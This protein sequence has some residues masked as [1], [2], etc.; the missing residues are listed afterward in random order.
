MPIAIG[1]SIFKKR[2]WLLILC[3][4]VGCPGLAQA[5]TADLTSP[6]ADPGQTIAVVIVFSNNIDDVVG[7]DST[8]IYDPAV[9]RLDSID[10]GAEFGDFAHVTNFTLAGEAR[11]TQFTF[12]APMNAAD[13]TVLTFHFT[14]LANAP[15]GPTQLQ[16]TRLD[17]GSDT[18]G[19]TPAIGLPITNTVTVN[20]GNADPILNTIGNQSIQVGNNLSL[21]VSATDTDGDTLTYGA[22]P[23]PT[24]ATLNP[25]TGDF[26]WT[27]QSGDEGTYDVTFTV[28]DDNGGSD[29][30]LVTITVTGVG[31]AHDAVVAS[32]SVNQGDTFS[33]RITYSNNSADVV[34]V[35]ATLTWDPAILTANS[36]TNGTTFAG[37]QLV[38]NLTTPGKALI[39][40]FSAGPSITAPGGEVLVVSFT[41]IASGSAVLNLSQLSF[42]TDTMTFPVS[43]VTNGFVTVQAPP[44][45]HP[46]LNSIGELSVQ[47]GTNLNFTVSATDADSDP[48]TYEA[49]PLPS[50]A[51]FSP[52]TGAFSWAP[53]S[54]QVGTYQVTFSVD[55]GNGGMDSETVDIT[56]FDD[57]SNTPPV[58][59]PI[60]N[61][62]TMEGATLT[63]MVS[64]LDADGDSLT[65]GASPLAGFMSLV[66]N[67]F[68]A[69][70]DFNAAGIYNVTFSVFDGT[71]TTTEDVQ[72]T[73]A[74]VNRD[75]VLT[76][77]GSKTVAELD[78]LSFAVLTNDPD[79]DTVTVTTSTLQPWMNF[80]GTTFTGTPGNSDAGTYQ[81]IFTANDG[82]TG[83]D[84]ETVTITVSE[85]NQAPDLKPVSNQ[86]VQEGATLNLGF[87][88]TDPDGDSLTLLFGGTEPWMS[89]D[90]TTL[91][92][93]PQTGDAGAYPVS[94]TADDG[95]LTDTENFTITVTPL[96]SNQPPTLDPIG[97]QSIDEGDNIVETIDAS[98][99]DGDALTFSLTGAPAWISLA[100]DTVTLTPGFEDAGGYVITV[101][102]S[103]GQLT[104]EETITLTVN[105]IN[106][107]P[108][109]TPTGNQF[110]NEGQS[111]GVSVSATDPDGDAVT[112]SLMNGQPWM[113]LNGA[114]ITLNPG[115]S[116]AGTYA[117]T[118]IA[119]DGDVQDSDTFSVTVFEV[120]QPPV[121]TAIGNQGVQEGDTINVAVTAS[122]P[123]GD[124]VT[125]ADG[126]LESWMSFDGSTFT[127]NPQTGDAGNYQVTF[128]ASD[129]ELTDEETITVSVGDVN[130]A[131]E[132]DPVGAQI[133]DE[134][135]TFDV[136][137]SASDPDGDAVTIGLTDP[138]PWMSLNGNVL[139]MAPGYDDAGVYQLT[140][141]AN[142]GELED[143]K[144]ITVTVIDVNRPPALNP[145]GDHM[146]EEGGVLDITL[147]ATDPDE[148]TLTFGVSPLP[149]WVSVNG[150][151][152]TLA[153]QAGDAGTYPLTVSV[154]DGELTDSEE[155][156]VTVTSLRA[157]LPPELDPVGDQEVTE[158]EV[159]SFMVSGDDPDED[160]LTY[161]ATGL[162]S[163]MSFT[164]MTFTAEPDKG[165]AG[166]YQVTFSISDGE[167]EDT[168]TITVT[169]L[170][171]P[172][173]QPPV[174]DPIGDQTV[175]EGEVVM[176]EVS[177]TDPDQQP[178]TFNVEPLPEGAMFDS[179]NLKFSWPT[180]KGD[181]G[182]YV[183]TVT[184]SNGYLTGTE[185]LTIYVVA[186]GFTLNAEHFPYHPALDNGADPV[187]KF[188]GAAVLKMLLQY[189]W[190]NRFDNPE[191][192]P[193]LEDPQLSLQQLL[194]EFGQPMNYPINQDL[195]RLDG[196]AMWQTIQDLDPPYKPFHYN[197]G[198]KARMS[199]EEALRDIAKWL[200]YPAGGGSDNP[201]GHGVDGY[202]VYIPGA[203]PLFGT[204][205]HWVVVKGIQATKDPWNNS[206][207]GVCGF[208]IN[209]PHPQG[210]GE[211]TFV[212]AEQFAMMYY[213]PMTEVDP[214]DPL[215]NKYVALL[216]PPQSDEGRVTIIR[217]EPRLTRRVQN[218]FQLQNVEMDDGSLKNVYVRD[219]LDEDAFALIEAAVAGIQ[220]QL[221]PFDEEFAA[222]F[223]QTIPR[224]PIFVDGLKGD[225]YL[226]PFE[227]PVEAGKVAEFRRGFR[228]GRMLDEE[229]GELFLDR[230]NGRIRSGRRQGRRKMRHRT[231]IVALIDAESG[232]FKEVTWGREPMR[233]LP[234]G[235]RRALRVLANHLNPTVE[236]RERRGLVRQMLEGAELEL[237]HTEGSFYYPVWRVYFEGLYYLVTQQGEIVSE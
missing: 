109:L 130:Q 46:I 80:D 184:A 47:A 148:D 41:A 79:G 70:P 1:I 90:G 161:T 185:T 170:P 143:S 210:L 205:D 44:N 137:L 140:I 214:D 219:H 105:D 121:L 144:T 177:G 213:R 102:V 135:D 54:P 187:E 98:D 35:D 18:T 201:G 157:N 134:G 91:T 31:S 230:Q 153:P 236:R 198:L 168:E 203:V 165:D 5:F 162:Q 10:N 22:T 61:K 152:L 119:S 208:W 163:W 87:T 53:T 118:V 220:E 78:T 14:V 7:V 106:R 194:Y 218:Y 97:D 77:I 82:N 84:Q 20:V 76:M 52:T 13:G 99:P 25:S 59:D 75:P 116:D 151:I 12:G 89:F 69:N 227:L 36:V 74:D 113:T 129:G 206:D 8:L 9:L 101:T 39:A 221:V 122:D 95:Q 192:P 172:M 181:A 58:L 222:L 169:V 150:N 85:A 45:S 128:T 32:A 51:I 71:D 180:Q 57:M 93:T 173:N 81:V 26:S 92:L 225:Y 171:T 131:P 199:L 175:K 204:Y 235:Q 191:G 160:S 126:G 17:F 156:A 6:A 164:D 43:N 66:G 188:S 141:T 174:L 29:S 67:T 3:G 64:G 114:L 189:I 209:D 197:F 33:I 139:S 48:L 110:V 103:D 115:F 2:L 212:T 229:G 215:Y 94:M 207:F 30:E 186:E 120:N 155:I 226:I 88:A 24:G 231:V 16:L 23:L 202:P 237:I 62:M 193:E 224:K 123:D 72:I 142:D 179:E 200:A 159:L 147:S 83:T 96:S 68:T 136:T 38:D 190:W 11:I 133:V 154:D 40:Q 27:P 60:G 117:V 28:D 146:V 196:W 223:V 138:Q 107:P 19:S 233:Y 234:V 145:V 63:F 211:N 176:F 55:D 15:A 228:K 216:E 124:T 232:A 56:V 183:V 125:I 158:G 111:L 37:F 42:G 166:D 178:L 104:D 149:G 65:F 100:G 50:G 4:A 217:S 49:T 195:M 182:E 86:I 112:Y 132:L 108:E 167:L 127:A 73:V 34:G 21:P